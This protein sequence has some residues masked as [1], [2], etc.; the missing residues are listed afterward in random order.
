[1]F[2]LVWQMGFLILAAFGFGVL[3]G[4]K[5]WS[6]EARSTE[7]DKARADILALRR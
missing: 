5:V 1:M 4:W 2:W 7:A 6:G 3:T